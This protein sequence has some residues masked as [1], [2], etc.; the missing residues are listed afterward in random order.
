MPSRAEWVGH[1]L[2]RAT[3]CLRAS[4]IVIATAITTAAE[5]SAAVVIAG[6]ESEPASANASKGTETEKNKRSVP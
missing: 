4:Q 5:T 1:I 3:L 2:R 6:D